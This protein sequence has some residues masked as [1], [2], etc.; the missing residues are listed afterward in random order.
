M[1]PCK[2]GTSTSQRQ[3]AR[4]SKT[5]KT[6][7]SQ[8]SRKPL[9][10]F[11]RTIHRLRFLLAPGWRK[12]GSL[13]AER[14]WPR[15]P[16]SNYPKHKGRVTN[17][18]NA[19]RHDVAKRITRSWFAGE[20]W[21]RITLNFIKQ[22]QTDSDVWISTWKT[23]VVGTSRSILTANQLQALRLLS[24]HPMDITAH[25]CHHLQTP[26]SY[27]ANGLG[28]AGTWSKF[29]HMS[30]GIHW[31]VAT[32]AAWTLHICR[33]PNLGLS[34]CSDQFHLTSC[35]MILAGSVFVTGSRTEQLD[36]TEETCMCY[37][38]IPMIYAHIRV[39]IYT[40]IY[41][42]RHIAVY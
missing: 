34:S 17:G 4:L 15:S 19:V 39:C 36:A 10:D 29:H 13:S 25:G 16:C 14:S 24:F 12:A 20:S 41:I 38:Y 9:S 37:I 30:T 23:S 22:N 40:H 26:A 33:N 18:D 6:S 1:A 32:T 5:F 2:R 42:H 35:P 3:T 21:V 27:F 11:K 7:N 8:Q 28:R 31:P